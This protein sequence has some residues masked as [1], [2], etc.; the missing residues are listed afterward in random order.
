MDTKLSDIAKSRHIFD[1]V[2]SYGFKLIGGSRMVQTH[3]PRP[4][5]SGKDTN[6]SLTLYDDSQKFYCFGCRWHGDALDFVQEMENCSLQQATEKMG[7]L[8]SKPLQQRPAPPKRHRNPRRDGVLIA[9]AL[10]H[11]ERCLYK[12]EEG[13]IGRSYLVRRNVDKATAKT[14]R[15]GYSSGTG[16]A[17]HFTEMGFPVKRQMKSGLFMK[18]PT[19]RFSNMIV[20]PELR[21][22]R[23]AWLT[24]R[25]IDDA[26][27]RFQSMPGVKPI[28]GIG[29]AD[30]DSELIVTEGVFDYVTLKRWNYNAVA[31]AGNGNIDRI[32]ADLKRVRPTSIVFALDSD[33]KTADMQTELIEKI[34][35]PVALVNLSNDTD[36]EVDVADLG[37]LADGRERFE[38]FTLQAKKARVK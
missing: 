8:P 19:E 29:T 27:P 12:T 15:I 32:I 34:Q 14:L 24:G 23:P 33:D 21:G 25:A 1:V 6:A 16:L 22:D 18:H 17:D 3:C 10:T 5:K 36:K 31:L 4:H 9:A 20:V 30:K 26:R 7:V 38:I 28:L 2:G 13:R 37:M 35:C 11:Y